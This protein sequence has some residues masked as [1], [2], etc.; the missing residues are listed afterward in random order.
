M[1]VYRSPKWR[2]RWKKNRNRLDYLFGHEEGLGQG[3]GSCS[4]SLP[5]TL[6]LFSTLLSTRQT[7]LTLAR[8]RSAIMRISNLASTLVLAASTVQAQSMSMLEWSNNTIGVTYKVAIPDSAGT[9]YPM[10]MSITAPVNTSWA[11]LSTGGCMLRSPLIV[12]WQ[13]GTS[14]AVS[15][16]WAT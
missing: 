12:A 8:R 5:L 1:K 15:A 7:S 13:N 10:V 14:V 9:S 16:R 4:P 11:G 2:E 3:D 6:P